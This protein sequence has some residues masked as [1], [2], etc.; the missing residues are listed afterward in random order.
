MNVDPE[1]LQFDYN[2]ADE[3][4][5][6]DAV[7]AAARDEESGLV[8]C[9][10]LAEGESLEVEVG[11][12]KFLMRVPDGE[13]PLVNIYARDVSERN[14]AMAAIDVVYPGFRVN[15]MEVGR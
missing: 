12:A 7:L 13:G 1:P 11:G 9:V 2:F 8:E 6:Y 4:G 15:A 10:P 3:R 5:L 14:R